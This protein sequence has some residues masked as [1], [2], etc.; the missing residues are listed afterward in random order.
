[1]P[2]SVHLWPSSCSIVRHCPLFCGWGSTAG[3]SV[4]SI[5]CLCEPLLGLPH[6]WCWNPISRGGRAVWLSSDF[7]FFPLLQGWTHSCHRFKS[8]PTLMFCL[9][10]Y[11]VYIFQLGIITFLNLFT[12]IIIYSNWQLLRVIFHR[13]LK[14]VTSQ[15]LWG[16]LVVLW[17]PS[18]CSWLL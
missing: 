6:G 17:V 15:E 7:R 16:R 11:Q 1:M 8:L 14:L 9:F 3:T 13:K 4:L 10:F 2:L 5:N 18:T 12:F